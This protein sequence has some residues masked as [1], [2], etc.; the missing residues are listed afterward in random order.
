[1]NFGH[2]SLFRFRSNTKSAPCILCHHLPPSPHVTQSTC[3]RCDI[4]WLVQVG[5]RIEVFKAAQL[6]FTPSPTVRYSPRQHYNTNQKAQRVSVRVFEPAKYSKKS[7][8]DP[9]PSGKCCDDSRGAKTPKGPAALNGQA[10]VTSPG[11][12]RVWKGEL[13]KTLARPLNFQML[14]ESFKELVDIS[15]QR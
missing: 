8:F 14:D 4:W 10:S 12:H 5:S 2:S 15:R 9:S 6:A 7:S 1:M 3:G 11:K 13:R